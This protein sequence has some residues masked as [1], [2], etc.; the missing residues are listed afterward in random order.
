MEF[1]PVI[2]WDLEQKQL[3]GIYVYIVHIDNFGGRRT[4]CLEG[5]EFAGV[6]GFLRAFL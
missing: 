1:E 5:T 6:G 4:S 2:F 3:S